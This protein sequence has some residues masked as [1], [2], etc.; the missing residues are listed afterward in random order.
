MRYGITAVGLS[1]LLL[2]SL[3][4]ADGDHGA[5]APRGTGPLW[6]WG[7]GAAVLLVVAVVLIR[8]AKRGT[9][10]GERFS[11]FSRNARLLLLRSPFSG[12]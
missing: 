5:H 7:L 8:Q 12:L 2:S 1:A 4:W 10:I 11:G 9:L 6:V 3:A